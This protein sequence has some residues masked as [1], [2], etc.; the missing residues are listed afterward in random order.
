M[1]LATQVRNGTGPS[2]LT[3]VS[4]GFMPTIAL[5]VKLGVP[6]GGVSTNAS[7]SVLTAARQ[8]ASQVRAAYDFM[9]VKGR[10]RARVCC[11]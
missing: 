10:A 7:L 8:Q 11:G 5:A 6:L 2:P 9:V 3:V 4:T 1:L